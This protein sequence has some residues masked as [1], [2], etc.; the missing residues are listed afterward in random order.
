[1]IEIERLSAYE[2][3]LKKL[4]KP[5][6][7]P[8]LPE[9]MERVLKALSAHHSPQS[10]FQDHDTYAVEGGTASGVRIYIRKDIPCKSMPSVGKKTGFR[11]VY[12]VHWS[13]DGRV[14]IKI[15]CLELFHKSE[16]SKPDEQR[17][18]AYLERLKR[19]Q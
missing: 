6:K 2:K 5:K 17:C 19:E 15:M 13:E 8:S 18:K 14:P 9:D 10:P 4:S 1:M 16:Q 7:Y 11:F 3:E 12:A